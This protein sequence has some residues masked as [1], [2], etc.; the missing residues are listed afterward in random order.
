[1]AQE[2][3]N[4]SSENSLAMLV[5]LVVLIAIVVIGLMYFIGLGNND[6][7]DDADIDV[8]APDIDNVVPLP[9]P[10]SET[11]DTETFESKEAPT[12]AP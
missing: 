5:V 10:T 1:M 3:A 7:G 9:A 2:N 11:D 12:T 6:L 8:N 4:P